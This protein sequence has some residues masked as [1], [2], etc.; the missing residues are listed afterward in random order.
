MR[1]SKSYEHGGRTSKSCSG[2]RSLIG[3]GEMVAV[4]GS[5][6]VGK[7]TLLHLLGTLD[8]PTA[9]I[10]LLRWRGAHAPGAGPVADFRNRTIGFVFQFH[11][12]LPEF[13][14]VENCAMPALIAR[15]S[16]DEADAR[17]P[18]APR[19]RRPQKSPDPPPGR[20]LGRRAAAGRARPRAR[21]GAERAPRR[22]ADRQPR[23]RHRRGDPPADRRAQPRARHDDASWSPTTAEL[24]R[25]SPWPTAACACPVD[26]A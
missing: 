15:T 7:S 11:H 2:D 1:S 24:A 4:V 9:G 10:D 23:H 13:S 12:L 18:Q 26:V 19:S 16:H 22:R 8:L 20:A 21:H 3:A 25:R 6:G 5:S 17:A 14:A